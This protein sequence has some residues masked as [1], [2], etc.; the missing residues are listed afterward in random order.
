MVIKDTN[1]VDEQIVLKY[2]KKNIDLS[3]SGIRKLLKL[4]KPI[5]LPTAT[6]GHFGQKPDRDFFPW[7]KA[8]LT[9]DHLIQKTTV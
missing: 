7:K 3:P 4:D 9:L 2:I 6:Y 5:Y 1:K 8:N